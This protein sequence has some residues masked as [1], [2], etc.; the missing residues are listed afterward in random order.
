MQLPDFLQRVITL[1]KD[2]L[3]HYVI[4]GKALSA[5]RLGQRA[6][7]ET[8]FDALCV[9]GTE[10]IDSATGR[11]TEKFKEALHLYPTFNLNLIE[12]SKN[13]DA[14]IARSAADVI[15]GLT[16]AQAVDM[17]HRIT[18]HTLGSALDPII[19]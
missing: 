5:Q 6:I 11:A 1:L 19:G 3:W 15:S 14:M 13:D 12:L 7:I 16:E 4:D 9:V 17:Y 2:I 10:K 18:G 8:I